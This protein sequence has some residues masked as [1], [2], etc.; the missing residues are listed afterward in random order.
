MTSFNLPIVTINQHPARH[1]AFRGAVSH[2]Q[3]NFL[4]SDLLNQIYLLSNQGALFSY[5][6]YRST[7]CIVMS[8]LKRPQ[9]GSKVQ[10]IHLTHIAEL[11]NETF[12]LS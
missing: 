6:L 7:E 9:G 10:N 1:A 4:Y 2:P 3:D 11:A 5:I 8:Y 12:D